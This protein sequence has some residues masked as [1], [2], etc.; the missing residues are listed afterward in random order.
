MHASPCCFLRFSLGVASVV[1]LL[2]AAPAW[3][4][5]L[6]DALCD[7]L[8]AVPFDADKPSG[9]EAVNQIAP[10]NVK[11]AISAC[12]KAASSTGSARRMWMQYG[13]ALEFATRSGDA[14]AAYEKAA[15]QGSTMAMLGL[16]DLYNS[17]RGV[18][19]DSVKAMSWLRKAADA[20]NAAAMNNLAA[21]YGLGE[22]AARDAVVAKWWYEKAASAGFAE[23]MYQLGLMA[24]EGD[25]APKDAAAAKSWFEKAAALDHPDAL[26][27][28][29]LMAANGT[30]GPKDEELAKSYLARAAALGNEDAAK[31]L[32]GLTCP[33]KLR[34]EKDSKEAGEICFDG[35]VP[36]LKRTGPR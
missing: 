10:E 15:S 20:G 23:S 9:V 12:E 1:L 30:G 33:F 28:L 31:V 11:E 2:A 4:D 24:Q 27:S 16:A 34:Q 14:A 18:P 19:Q 25:G 17:G 3:P 36:G 22:G 32:H 6:D 7:R 13:R 21:L 5:S 8:A 26:Y 29:G 35:P